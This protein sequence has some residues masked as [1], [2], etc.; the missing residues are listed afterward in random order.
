MASL[1]PNMR[2]ELAE[3][4]A[5]S[6]SAVVTQLVVKGTSTDGVEVE[7]P[8]VVLDLH[9]GDHVTRMETFDPDQRDIALARFDELSAPTPHLENAATRA[10]AR[11]VDAFNRRDFD[12]FVA[13]FTADGRYED[14]RKGL[15]DEGPNPG[16][17]TRDI[18]RDASKLADGNGDCRHQGTSLGAMS[19]QAP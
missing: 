1:V 6:A 15:R 17:R 12:G 7:L 8:I 19:R 13:V 14:R 2:M 10:E 5:H 4:L 3:V 18:F 9:D 11:L 16:L